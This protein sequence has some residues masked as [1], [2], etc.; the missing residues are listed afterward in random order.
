MVV[1]YY[2]ANREP[3][4]SKVTAH[5]QEVCSLPIVSVTQKPLKLGTN[6]C[7]GDIGNSYRSE[8]VQIRNGLQ[9]IDSEYVLVAEADTLYP[10]EYFEKRDF[11]NTCHRYSNVW[12]M[13]N[14]P[15]FHYKGLSHCAQA[16]NRQEWLERIDR[17]LHSWDDPRDKKKASRMQFKCRQDGLWEGT[18]PVITL[19]TGCGVSRKTRTKKAVAPQNDL[20]YWGNA[21]QLLSSL[22]D[23]A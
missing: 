7:V 1:L 9:A 15:K 12:V 19:K 8:F 18:A 4:E 22:Y 10:P 13:W 21:A 23:D 3:I 2:S 11:H 6:I 14:T 16:V 17:Y 5:L 20:P